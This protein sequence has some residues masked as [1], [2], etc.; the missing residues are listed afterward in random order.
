MDSTTALRPFYFLVTFWGGAYVD[1]FLDFCLASLMAPG[2]LPALK[3]TGWPCRIV[4]CTTPADIVHLKTRP[5]FNQVA[6]GFPVDFI[7][8]S[9]PGEGEGKMLTMSRGHVLLSS[10]AHRDRAL[11]VYLT[12][13]MIFSARAIDCVGRAARDGVRALLVPAIR[14]SQEAVLDR[15]AKDGIRVGG[16]PL[17]VPE[18]KL[19]EIG[20]ESLHSETRRYEF[21]KPWFATFPISVYWRAA[22]GMVLYTF[23]WAP[24]LLDYGAMD[25]AHDQSTFEKWTMDGDYVYRNFDQPGHTRIVTDSDELMLVTLTREADLRFDLKPHWA[26]RGELARRVAIAR[27][28]RHPSMDPLKR[29]IFSTA[30]LIHTGSPDAGLRALRARSG[31]IIDRSIGA[32]FASAIG[33]LLILLDRRTYAP[34]IDSHAPL[35]GTVYRQLRNAWRRLFAPAAG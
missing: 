13:D 4:I 7:E 22:A 5:F 31:E 16:L 26:M 17:A 9:G 11:A 12:P 34:M 29:R 6:A 30:T 14:Y 23:S 19:A 18:R 28:Y 20:I 15:F 21:E 8:F 3:S 35:L 10:R 32:G 2:N 33:I 24:M 25:G 1:D 27:C